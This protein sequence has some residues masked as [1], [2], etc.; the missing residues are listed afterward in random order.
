MQR[1]AQLY[2]ARLGMDE[3]RILA[4][5]LAHSGLSAAWDMDDGLDPGYSLTCAELLSSLAEAQR[6]T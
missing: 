6:F 2:A 3:T 5:A 4:F 1:L